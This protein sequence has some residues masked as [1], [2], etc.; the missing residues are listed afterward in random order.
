MN[1][2]TR[3]QEILGDRIA[4][5]LKNHPIRPVLITE[6]DGISNLGCIFLSRRLPTFVGDFYAK[7]KKKKK[8]KWFRVNVTSRFNFQVCLSYI[9]EQILTKYHKNL[10]DL[11]ETKKSA[12]F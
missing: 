1:P 10:S 12:R 9:Q 6:N 11:L 4:K 2:Y 8:K 3:A 5:V 7:K